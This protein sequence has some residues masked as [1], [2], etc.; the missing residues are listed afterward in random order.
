MASP[1]SGCDNIL[2]LVLRLHKG[3]REVTFYP[4]YSDGNP[5]QSFVLSLFSIYFRWAK[6]IRISP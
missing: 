4:A 2:T 5:P 1:K 6:T 3:K